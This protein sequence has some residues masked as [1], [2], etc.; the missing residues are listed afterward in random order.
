[1]KTGFAWEVNRHITRCT[2]PVS[3][4]LLCKLGTMAEGYK[5]GD[6]GRPVDPCGL[7]STYTFRL[8]RMH[9]IQTIVTVVPVSQHVCQ[10]RGFTRLW[11]A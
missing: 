4:V 10:S 3:V 2:I 9:Q 8:N 1:M 5:N 7:G 6:Q 11:F